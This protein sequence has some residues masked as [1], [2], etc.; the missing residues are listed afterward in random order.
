MLSPK[1]K[2][3]LDTMATQTRSN[4]SIPDSPIISLPGRSKKTK[5]KPAPKPASVPVLVETISPEG[6]NASAPASI[7]ALALVGDSDETVPVSLEVAQVDITVDT[8]DDTKSSAD[9]KDTKFSF[10]SMHDPRPTT[11]STTASFDMKSAPNKDHDDNDDDDDVDD[12]D[13]DADDAITPGKQASFN[14][15]FLFESSTSNLG[16]AD[17]LNGSYDL[18][19]S[20][21]KLFT[22]RGILTTSPT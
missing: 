6:T 8:D 22:N 21:T 3:L 13:D 9:N 7:D 15:S 18:S 16:L 2:S 10:A 5:L 20:S 17:E 19:F 1:P 12:D 14:C 4:L 11:S